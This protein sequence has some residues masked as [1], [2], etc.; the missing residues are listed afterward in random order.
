ME[1]NNVMMYGCIPP[2]DEDNPIQLPDK[3]EFK[4]IQYSP[5]S[6]GSGLP[7]SIHNIGIQG[8]EKAMEIVINYLKN[9]LLVREWITNTVVLSLM[10]D[11]EDK[12]K[13]WCEMK[14]EEIM[15]A[16]FGGGKE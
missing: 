5:L 11:L 2:D 9:N 4:P 6:G 14:A 10:D 15:K 1:S 8:F 12:G 3:P 13:E 16:I 7:N